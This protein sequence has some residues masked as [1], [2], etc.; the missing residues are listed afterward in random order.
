MH[1]IDSS[2]GDIISQALDTAGAPAASKPFIMSQVAYETGGFMSGVSQTD[3]NYSGIKYS[4]SANGDIAS[5]GL[6][7]P[8][9][10][11]YAHYDDPSLWA[12]DYLRIISMNRGQGAPIDANSI[13]D[14]ASRLQANGY[15]T[16]TLSNYLGGLKSYYN[17][18][19]LNY[20]TLFLA[21]TLAETANTGLSL[22]GLG[23]DAYGNPTTVQTI[24]TN[25]FVLIGIL[26]IL[27]IYVIYSNQNGKK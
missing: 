12:Q 2:I 24:G 18:I 4:P 23:T 9:G 25:V 20:P 26:L 14:Y 3:N 15:F 22:L 7:S 8:E 21:S 13:E 19:S 16:D 1:Q 27:A 11:H 6:Q 10:N 17:T 5:M